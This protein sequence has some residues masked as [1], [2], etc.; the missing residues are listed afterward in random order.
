M[1]RRYGGVV[2]IA[3][4]AAGLA[5]ALVA[6]HQSSGGLRELVGYTKISK[7]VNYPSDTGKPV[8]TAMRFRYQSRTGAFR[9]IV[10]NFDADG[11]VWTSI[12]FSVPGR[13]TFQSSPDNTKV[14]LISYASEHPAPYSEAA[15]RKRPDFIREDSVAGYRTLVRRN[16]AKDSSITAEFWEAPDLNG[17]P[18][19][20][21]FTTKAGVLKEETV[22]VIPGEPDRLLYWQEPT[23]PVSTAEYER[24]ASRLDQAGKSG[25]AAGMRKELDAVRPGFP[26]VV[27][28]PPGPARPRS[29]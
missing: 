19:R 1:I 28:D 20:A 13:G 22:Q 21:V 8:L 9:Q 23:L 27:A 14:T 15:A 26:S 16:A 6:R 11:T 17:E 29:K 10:T 7:M 5:V 24:R 25:P 2:C 3:V 12:L 4:F 18:L